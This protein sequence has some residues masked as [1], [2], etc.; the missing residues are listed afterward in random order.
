MRP[1]APGDDARVTK[2]VVV[3][4]GGF[5]GLYLAKSLANRSVA[6]T[7][8]DRN[9]HHLFQ[10]LLYQIATAALAPGSIA[11]PIRSILNQARNV[12]VLLAEVIGTDL[13]AN[14]VRLADGSA[15]DYDYLVLAPGAR[16]CYFGKPEWEELAPGLKSLEDALEI[17]RRVLT[18]FELA[19]REVDPVARRRLLTFVV[20]GGGP[21][22]VELAGALAEIRRYALRRDFRRIDSR[23]ASV[24]LLEGG[25]RLLPSYPAVLSD[26][27]KEALRHLG[28]DVR[29]ET[30]VTGVEPGYVHAADWRIPAATVIWAAGNAAS[31]LL[32][33][34][35]A[36]QDRQGRVLVGPDCSVPG[37]PNVFV[38]GDAAAFEHQPGGTLPGICPVAI[39]MGQYAA[40]AIE[41]DLAGK[42]RRPFRYRDKGQL[43]VIGRGRGV[44]D[45]GRFETAGFT[46]WLLWVFVHIFFLIG[47]RNRVVVMF[48]WAWSYLTFQR[49][50]RLITGVW[51]AAGR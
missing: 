51:R 29:T 39:Q 22:G 5:A 11:S 16:H 46:A 20:I 23:D 42:P 31:P 28:V 3:V 7:V 24:L 27:A 49:G 36:P 26:R 1:V 50:A 44:A 34:L 17:R 8:I 48:E 21:T 10:P 43:A 2:R 41:A 19:E 40:A 37:R 38:I 30:M 47:F 35:G 6:V 32:E 33:S 25:P 4:G 15:V 45:I 14:R 9:N 18:A 13:D 12:E